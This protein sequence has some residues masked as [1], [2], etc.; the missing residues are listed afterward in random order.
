MDTLHTAQGQLF[1][2]AASLPPGFEFEADFVTRD[3]EAGVL[4]LA[5]TLPLREAKYRDYTANRRVF[6]WRNGAD[7]DDSRPAAALAALPAPLREL[8]ERLA[9][10]AGIEAAAFEHV[11]LS[12]YRAGTP[13]GWHRDAPMYELIVGVSLASP[14]RLRLRPW[15]PQAPKKADIV[16]LDLAPRSAYALRGSAR[17][18]WQHSLPPVRALR[19]SVTMRT[20]R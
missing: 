16:A 2:V 9:V 7:D 6:A 10:W 19:Y 5:A 3:E 12:E 15:P 1:D 20:R 11:L 4:A 18:G 14:A 13:L 8:R 17:W